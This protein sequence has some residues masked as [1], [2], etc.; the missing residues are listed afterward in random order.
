MSPF[1]DHDGAERRGTARAAILVVAALA[2]V[3]VAGTLAAPLLPRGGALFHILY[4]PLCHQLP[5]RSLA[6]GDG[7]MAVCARCAGLYLGGVLGLVAAAWSRVVTGRAPR[8]LWLVLAF[9]PTCL[10]AVLA[11]SLG[12]GVSNVPRLSITLPAGAAAGLFLAAG[13]ADLARSGL[14]PKAAHEH[15]R[16]VEGVDG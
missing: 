6:V 10:D 7:Y 3:F 12:V 16:V 1:A 13:V 15:P 14:R 11:W 8:P 2:L 5:E 9:A 4:S